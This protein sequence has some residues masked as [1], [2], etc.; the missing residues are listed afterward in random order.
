MKI[1]IL[2]S[3][4]M[5]GH[6]INNRLKSLTNFTVYNAA[7]E[8]VNADTFIFNAGEKNS[9]ISVFD[10]VK[11]DIIINAVGVLVKQANQNPA[12]AILINSYFPHM[13]SLLA[14]ERNSY[15]IHLSTDCVF[16]GHKGNYLVTDAKDATD[17]YGQSKGLG[18]LSNSNDLTIRTSII[19]PEIKKGGT[20]LLD[21]YLKSLGTISGYNKVFWSGITTLE[22]CGVIEKSIA[23]QEKGLVQISNNEKI[24][25]Y[26]L[27]LLMGKYFNKDTT[28]INKEEKTI[29]DKSLICSVPGERYN[30]P[31]YEKMIKSLSE[32]VL[33]NKNIYRDSYPQLFN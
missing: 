4:G 29:H 24:S 19:G 16:S 13:L 25:K 2:G 8:K 31:S 18:E 26:D 12:N 28:L 30:V 1:L 14:K 21:W 11:P 10:E 27:L 7:R 32:Y 23:L 9:V 3:G 17:F 6:I 5:A 20:G 22:L 15:V 33:N